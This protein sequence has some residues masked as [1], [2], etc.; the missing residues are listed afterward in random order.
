[1]AIRFF[2]GSPG[3]GKTTMAVKLAMKNRR[4]YKRTFLNFSNTVP[5]CA[6]CDMDG[7]G[8][9][10]FPFHSWI[11]FDESG[12]D[13]NSRQYKKFPKE[14][15]AM[16]KKHRHYRIDM[17]CFSQSWSDTDKIIRDL[18]GELWY[19]KK[20]GPWTLARRVYKRITVDKN[21]E[22]II[23]G[24]HMAS[25]LWLLIWPLQLGFPFEKK[26]MLTFRPFYYKYFDS[27]DIDETIEEKDFPVKNR[28]RL[29][30]PAPEANAAT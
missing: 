6:S 2:F 16:Y 27:W 20:I 4:K 26:F 23:D 11:G 17:D 19:L 29:P 12:I 10:R 3:C 28:K 25:M 24:Y 15:I 30:E 18:S 7:F 21:T 13:A 1:M 22:Q 9:W 14:A 8:T 5:D